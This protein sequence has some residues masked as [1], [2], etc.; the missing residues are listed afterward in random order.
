MSAR[1]VVVIPCFNEADRLQGRSFVAFAA[2]RPWLRLLFV[3]DGSSDDT[4]GLLEGLAAEAPGRIG[5]LGLKENLGKAEAVRR[6]FV[7][8]LG[9]PQAEQVGFWDA[10]LATPLA[11]IDRF[12]AVLDERPEVE[13]VLGSRIQRLGSD[14][15]RR[16]RRHYTGRV[17]AT[18]VSLILGLRV[19]DTQCGAKLFRVTPEL[20]QIFAEPFISRWLFDV[21]ILA[22]WIRAKPGLTRRQ[23]EELAL[24]Y[25]LESWTDVAGSRLG[26]AD[27]VRAPIEL[28]RIRRRYFG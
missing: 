22:R 12:T 4:G 11:V 1:T 8:A 6:G 27:F 18:M 24:E 14:I 21:E 20:R 9:A 3:D 2:E 7:E 17:A 10:D 25:P 16:A 5:C 15:A 28:L 26:R 23:L 19:Y 13:M